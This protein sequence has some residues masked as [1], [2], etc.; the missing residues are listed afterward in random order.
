[1]KE[2]ARYNGN[3]AELVPPIVHQALLN[4]LE[5]QEKQDD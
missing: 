2:V 1:M 3:I 5:I 4:K